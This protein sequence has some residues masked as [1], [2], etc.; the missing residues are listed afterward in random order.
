MIHRTYTISK[1]VFN[2]LGRGGLTVWVGAGSPTITAIRQNLQ[3][4]AP[5]TVAL[6]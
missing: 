6:I 1:K 4:P 2:S 5:K 3:K